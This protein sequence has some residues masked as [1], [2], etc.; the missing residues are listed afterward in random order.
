MTNTTDILYYLKTLQSIGTYLNIEHTGKFVTVSIDKNINNHFDKEEVQEHVERVA[1]LVTLLETSTFRTKPKDTVLF[2]LH[3]IQELGEY[4]YL[5]QEG[6][7][8]D[9]H[10]DTHLN[11]EFQGHELQVRLCRIEYLS[12]FLKSL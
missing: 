2:N 8:L 10:I 3:I 11:E 1:G 12:K 5:V 6:Q 4:I 9:V 7:T